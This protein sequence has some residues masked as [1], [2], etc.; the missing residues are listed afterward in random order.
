MIDRNDI[1]RIRWDSVVIVRLRCFLRNAITIDLLTG[2]P[3]ILTTLA[4]RMF[5]DYWVNVV[6]A[7]IR[8]YSGFLAYTLP[9]KYHY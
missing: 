5:V 8:L 3:L 9:L 6:T 7:L 4:R 1:H 2:L